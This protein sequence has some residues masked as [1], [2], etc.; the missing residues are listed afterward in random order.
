MPGL[1]GKIVC[2]SFRFD[3]LTL[4]LAV[5]L[6]LIGGQCKWLILH[7]GWDLSLKCYSMYHGMVDGD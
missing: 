2:C 6:G 4:R 3:C 7:E 1:H 5:H